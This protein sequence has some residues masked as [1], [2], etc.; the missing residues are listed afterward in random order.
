MARDILVYADWEGLAGPQRL[1]TLHAR[2]GAGKEVFEFEFAAEVLGRA[3][4][5]GVQLDPRLA[6]F[7][8][9][10]HAPRGHANFGVFADASPDR[11]GRLLMQRRLE[12][13]Q[14]AGT[15]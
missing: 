10:Q 11:W 6:P 12:R 9:P 7:D 5:T 15:V 8:G 1:G 4:L 2:A 14:R 3:E 13:L